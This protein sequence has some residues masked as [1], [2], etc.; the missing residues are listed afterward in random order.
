[1]LVVLLLS[2]SA[3]AGNLSTWLYLQVYLPRVT[4]VLQVMSMC[5]RLT[6]AEHS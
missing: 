2:A 6:E 4:L 5:L 1:M 3:G